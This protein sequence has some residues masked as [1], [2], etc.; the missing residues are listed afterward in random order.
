METLWAPWRMAYVERVKR[1][2]APGDCI[3]CAALAGA[4]GEAEMVVRTT[5][6]AVTMLN[7]Y[8]YNP[9]HLMVAPARHLGDL[10]GFSREELAAVSAEIGLATRVLQATLSCE[11][12][13]GG[14][15]QGRA[16][17]AGIEDHLHFHLVPRWV[18]DT[19]FMPVLGDVKVLP[20]HLQATAAKLRSAF[21]EAA[22]A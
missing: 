11:G 8:P 9:G 7:L 13:N 19:N 12:L 21:A 3:F 18:G 6:E 16:A 20:E 17:G 1:P 15:N 4:E 2:A 14:W 5:P 22:S 10:G